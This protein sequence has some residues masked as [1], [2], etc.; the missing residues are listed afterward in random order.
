MADGPV[1]P[2]AVLRPLTLAALPAAVGLSTSVGWNQDAADW[3]RLISLHPE[4]CV[5]AWREETLIGTAT[6]VSY[7][8]ALAWLGMVI[9]AEEARGQGLGTRLVNAAL[10]TAP[11]GGKAVIGL[12]ATSLGAG[13]Y[14]RLGFEP[15]ADIDR[16][17][18]VLR[19]G[20]GR[21]GQGATV[22]PADPRDLS[23]LTAFDRR[24]AAVDRSR[25]LEHLAGEAGATLLV[26]ERGSDLAGYAALRSGRTRR[27]LGPLV[28][29]D[30]GTLDDLL[31]AAQAVAGGDAVY[32]DA[33]RAPGRSEALAAWGLEVRRSLQRMTRPAAP[34][35]MG[36]ALVAATAFEWG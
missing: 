16:W 10:A 35:L 1:T 2:E 17:E 14:R 25:L 13:L 26:A 20:A 3:E 31:R 5:G 8:G 34:A 7:G 29:L 15:V 36:E 21:T 4:G 24:H 33:L 9:V 22:R 11:E 18:G 32:L 19:P 30:S 6:L 27:H 12:D 28:A 23:R